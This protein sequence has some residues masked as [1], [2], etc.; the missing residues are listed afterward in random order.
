MQHVL[1]LEGMQLTVSI[2]LRWLLTL[3]FSVIFF[4]IKDVCY[5]LWPFYTS[6]G[7]LYSTSSYPI[8]HPQLLVTLHSLITCGIVCCCFVI[9]TQH[10]YCNVIGWQAIL[11][12]LQ[13]PIRTL[14]WW[15]IACFLA[16]QVDGLIDWVID[17]LV[18]GYSTT[19]LQYCNMLQAS[20]Q[21]W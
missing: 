15:V 5:N 1:S 21:Q 20:S 16:C 9:Y 14:V 19:V 11:H 12:C 8:G 10:Q 6:R 3:Q 18:D 2:I 7:K 17:W 13:Q 4:G